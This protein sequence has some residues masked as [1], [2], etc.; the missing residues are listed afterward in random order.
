MKI[1]ISYLSLVVEQYVECPHISPVHVVPEGHLALWP[2][3]RELRAHEPGRV[4][5]PLDGGLHV[6]VVS[7]A[8]PG[9]VVRHRARVVGVGPA[10]VPHPLEV[11]Q[12]VLAPPADTTLKV[13]CP[14]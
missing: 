12:L 14:A 10:V 3:A 13:T 7:G 4:S 1:S 6:D 11:G 8:V 9:G 5:L 2:R